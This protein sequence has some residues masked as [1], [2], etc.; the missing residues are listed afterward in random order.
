MLKQKSHL[1]VE[2]AGKQYSLICDSDSPLGCLHDALMQMKG[3]CVERMIANQK[4]EEKIAEQLK[5]SDDE[6]SL[7]V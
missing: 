1:E 3:W 4:E 7:E 5:A 2:I 6:T